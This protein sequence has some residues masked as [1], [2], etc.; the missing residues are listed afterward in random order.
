MRSDRI[1]EV[2]QGMITDHHFNPVELCIGATLESC[3]R[4]GLLRN[5]VFAIGAIES[6]KQEVLEGGVFVGKERTPNPTLPPQ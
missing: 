1:V 4:K 3:I 2:A 5:P 6:V